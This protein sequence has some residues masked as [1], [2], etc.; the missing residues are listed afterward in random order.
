MSVQAAFARL[1]LRWMN[2]GSLGPTGSIEESRQRMAALQRWVPMPPRGTQ[3]SWHDIGGI[4]AIRV[5]RPESS[6]RRHILYLHGGAYVAGAPA[7]YKDFIWRIASAARAQVICPVYRLAPEHP[8]PAALDDAVAAYRWL[9]ADGADPQRT[10]LMGDSAGGGLVLATLMRLR[11]EGA[12]LPAAAVALSP[13]T[14]LALTGASIARNAGS[15]AIVVA[16]EMPMLADHYLAGADPRTPYASPLYGDPSGLPP[17]LIQ[18]SNLETLLDDS[19]R[20]AERLRAAGRT[21]ELEIWPRVP[22]V[23]QT[24]AR[25]MPEARQAIVRI[26]T[27]VQERC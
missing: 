8:F 20:M 13:W 15:D 25:I 7:L 3:R 5:A 26:G 17:V 18:V 16:Q 14:D 24:W 6:D 21:V 1:V 2:K 10:V 9:I 19:V 4:R 12:P 11:D 27:F 22:H 23:W